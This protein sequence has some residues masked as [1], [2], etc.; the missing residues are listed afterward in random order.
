MILLELCE[1]AFLLVFLLCMV[2][3]VVIPL[4]RETPYF[5]FFRR[6]ARALRIRKVLRILE[7]SDHAGQEGGEHDKTS[8]TQGR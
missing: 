2:T 8:H 5:P 1:W 4:W 7:E 3:Q 6:Q